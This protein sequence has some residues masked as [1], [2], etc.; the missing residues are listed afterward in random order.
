[1][2]RGPLKTLSGSGELAARVTYPHQMVLQHQLLQYH[3]M[4]RL[5]DAVLVQDP[6]LDND[7]YQMLLQHL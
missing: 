6:N 3:L 7:H 5:T 1:L 4:M 2:I